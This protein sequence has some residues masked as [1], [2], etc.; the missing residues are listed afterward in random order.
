MTDPQTGPER[1]DLVVWQPWSADTLQMARASAKPLLL[2]IAYEASL[3]AQH[4]AHECFADEATAQ[5]M[6]ELFVNIKI[7]RDERPDLD[8]VG[9]WA[10][11]LLTRQS[12]GWPL[13]VFLSHDGAVPFFAST[14]TQREAG[15]AGPGYIDVLL[16]VAHY[17]HAE[18]AAIAG[19][20]Q[21]LHA[22][23]QA[24]FGQPAA[25]TDPTPADWRRARQQLQDLFDREHGGWGSAPKFPRPAAIQLLLRAWQATAQDA[26][27]DLQALFM[28]MLTLQRLAESPLHDQTDGG[29]SSCSLDGAWQTPNLEKTLTDNA[30]LLS[31]YAAATLATGDPFHARVVTTTARFLLQRLQ[32]PGGGFVSGLRHSQHSGAVS[33]GKLL[34]G[35]NSL[36]V[37]ALADAARALGQ[38]EL[39][40]VACRTLHRLQEQLWRDDRLLASDASDAPAA[41]LNDYVYLA[42]AILTLQTLRFDPGQLHWA[43]E[44]MDLVLLHFADPVRGGFH[45]T[46]DEQPTLL[47]RCR[48]FHDDTLPSGNSM[49]AQVLLRLGALLNEPRYLQ[50]AKRCLQ[51]GIGLAAAQ[52]INHMNLYIALDEQLRPPQFVIIR[53]S[54]QEMLPWQT[55][56]ARLYAPR[57][58]VLCIDCSVIDLPEALA[59]CVPADTVVAYVLNAQGRSAAL[60]VLPLVLDALRSA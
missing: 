56:L 28:A 13:S 43:C 49:A 57:V 33:G 26:A 35:C 23:W 60:S 31:T 53:G 9:Q 18:P 27:P 1:P 20:C 30:L 6:N 15:Q 8:Q 58:M 5:V 40:D 32:L 52:P 22:T 16:R 36:A 17:Y 46:V 14:T 3:A 47:A 29:F 39:T 48:L 37:R 2:F 41:G 19:Q 51:A 10:H 25:D 50:S 38:D 55:A 11:R 44:L 7:D 12:G 45:L 34:A 54:L 24:Q 59:A 21:L 4:M 42:D